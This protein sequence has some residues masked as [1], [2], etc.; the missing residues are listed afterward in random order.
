MLSANTKSWPVAIREAL[1]ACRSAFIGLFIFSFVINLLALTSSLYMMQVYDR[2]LASRN[3]VTLAMLTAM[4]LAALLAMAGLE[5]VRGRAMVRIG[6]WL[7]RRLGGPVLT[8][9]A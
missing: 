4:A 7:D 1:G 9:P 3:E 8:G 6:L 5:L 2:V